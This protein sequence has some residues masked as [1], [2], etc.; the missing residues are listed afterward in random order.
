LVL[1]STPTNAPVVIDVSAS[2]ARAIDHQPLL[3]QQRIRARIREVELRVAR[4][5]YRPRFDLQALYRA[6]GL[7]DNL[8]QALEMMA[9]NDFYDWEFGAELSMPLGLNA[10]HANVRAAE[11]QLARDRAILDQQVQS[12]VYQINETILR[13]ESL[14]HEYRAAKARA[15][16]AKEWSKYARIRFYNPPP[17]GRNE[18]WLLSALDDYLSAIRASAEAE[19]ETG[20]LLALYNTELARLKEAEGTLLDEYDIHLL[21]DPCARPF[22]EK[23]PQFRTADPGEAG[24][25]SAVSNPQER[26]DLPPPE[27]RAQIFDQPVEHDETHWAMFPIDPSVARHPR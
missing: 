7:D 17:A 24:T 16:E 11:L 20:E 13:I 25:A 15:D 21:C 23:L 27:L 19:T 3:I 18:N 8:D 22:V 9:R 1:A 12:T 6:N 5:Q 14:Y 2:I 10:A 26:F 4:N